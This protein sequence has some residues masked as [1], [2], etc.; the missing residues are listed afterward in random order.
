MPIIS[1]NH[2]NGNIELINAIHSNLETDMRFDSGAI[3]FITQLIEVAYQQEGNK[4]IITTLKQF[5]LSIYRASNLEK[6]RTSINQIKYILKLTNIMSY[7]KQVTN[8]INEG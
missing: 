1:W 4:T 6:I 5:K 8:N 3:K 2:L 7:V